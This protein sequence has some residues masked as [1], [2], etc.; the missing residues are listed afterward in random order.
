MFACPFKT[1]CLLFKFAFISCVLCYTLSYSSYTDPSFFKQTITE[2]SIFHD[3]CFVVYDLDNENHNIPV[4][5]SSAAI[6]IL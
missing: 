4:E 5:E 2:V 1:S 6:Q 3:V